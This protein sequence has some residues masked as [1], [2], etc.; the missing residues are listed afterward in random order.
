[1]EKTMKLR[2]L[3]V[4]G[5]VF[6]SFLLTATASQAGRFELKKVENG[7]LRL[8]TKTGIVAFCSRKNDVWQC[9]DIDDDTRQYR[10]QLEKLKAENRQLK[11]QMTDNKSLLKRALPSDKQLDKV[12]DS[13]EKMMRRFWKFS[14]QQK[15]P[16]SQ[17]L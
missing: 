8:D 9:S 11:K 7:F 10:L 16:E 13:F 3:A 17:D 15:Q 6:I 5:L 4:C 1:M 14:R 12:L 2:N